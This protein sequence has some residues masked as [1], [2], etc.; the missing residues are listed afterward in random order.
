MVLL[1]LLMVYDNFLSL[2]TVAEHQNVGIKFSTNLVIQNLNTTK[3]LH[4][5]FNFVEWLILLQFA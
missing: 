2:V 1:K 4:R 3:I 5:I